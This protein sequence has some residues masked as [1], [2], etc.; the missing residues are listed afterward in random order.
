ML[1]RIWPR[2]CNIVQKM[3]NRNLGQLGEN[4]AKEYLK[5]KGYKIVEKNCRNK[6][7]EID[8]ICKEKDSLVFVEVKTRIGEKFGL[9]ED[10]INKNKTYRLIRNAQA[11]IARK[12]LNM[13]N[14]RIDAVCIVLDKNKRPIRIGHYE[15]IN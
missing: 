3:W 10:A 6:R 5:K 4:I 15:N 1:C 13:I 7:G 14:Y 8:L 11:Y 2:R 9:P 12:G